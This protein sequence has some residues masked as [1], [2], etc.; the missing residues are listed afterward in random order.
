MEWSKIKNI[1]LVILLTVNLIL[2][3]VVGAREY[4]SARYDAQTLDSAVT[5]LASNGIAVD[6]D[7]PRQG[8]NLP[9]LQ[10]EAAT[11]DSQEQRD[12]VSAL[13]GEIQ[14]VDG[15]A[16]GTRVTY[17]G[18]RGVAELSSDGY[19]TVSLEPGAL[20]AEDD[21]RAQGAA[22]LGQLGI[23]A[24][25]AGEGGQSGADVL[26]YWQSWNGT[27]VFTC[28]STVTWQDGSV[29]SISGQRVLGNTNPVSTQD[30]LTIPTVLVRFLNGMSQ[31]GYVCSAITGMSLG[32]STTV[33]ANRLTPV[34]GV[35]TDTGRYYVNAVTG[36]FGRVEE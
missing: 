11:Q 34:W 26:A 24:I 1:I 15:S 33:S 6:I 16:G 17:H 35:K 22:L 27:P 2:L 25:P 8:E 18:E 23:Q 36:A 4:Q 9:I 7:L 28:K 21:H 29:R 20:S 30:L 12:Q 31:H 14:R 5:L 10:M 13:L 3:G 19:F 32:Y